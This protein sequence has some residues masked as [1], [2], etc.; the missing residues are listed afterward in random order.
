MDNN[1]IQGK[2]FHM[3]K[4]FT[5]EEQK[6]LPTVFAS[7]PKM[8]E[9]VEGQT[10]FYK[11]IRVIHTTEKLSTARNSSEIGQ[12]CDSPFIKIYVE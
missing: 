11:I 7:V 2:C 1:I 9:F 12:F 10:K 5:E 6:H 3:N 4:S 8:D